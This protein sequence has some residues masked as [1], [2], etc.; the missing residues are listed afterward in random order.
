MAEFGGEVIGHLGMGHDDFAFQE[1][2]SC[3][4]LHVAP[5][6]RRRGFKRVRR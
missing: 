4:G 5:G 2:R 6:V 3:G 1:D